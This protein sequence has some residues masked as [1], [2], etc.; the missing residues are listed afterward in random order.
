MLAAENAAAIMVACYPNPLSAKNLAAVPRP[1]Q[2]PGAQQYEN[3]APQTGC[4]NSTAA[5]L[6]SRCWGSLLRVFDMVTWGM[7]IDTSGRPLPN[8][9]FMSLVNVSGLCRHELTS[10]CMTQLGPIGCFLLNLKDPALRTPLFEPP[11]PPAPPGAQQPQNAGAGGGGGD[12]GDD[13]PNLVA[14]LVGTLGGAA[15][16]AALG[17][18][19]ALLWRRRQAQARAQAGGGKTAPDAHDDPSAAG[20]RRQSPPGDWEQASKAGAVA[21]DSGLAS[22]GMDSRDALTHSRYPAIAL[23]PSCAPYGGPSV[24]SLQTPFKPGLLTSITVSDPAEGAAAVEGRGGQAE[25]GPATEDGP[26]T[27]AVAEGPV[28]AVTAGSGACRGEAHDASAGAPDPG[29]PV[30]QLTSRVLGKGT[31]GRVLEGTL[32]GMPVA[33][34]QMGDLFEGVS[35]EKTYAFVQELEVLARCEHPNIVRLLAAC[36]KPP[37]PCIVMELMATSLDKVLYGR[38]RGSLLP[39][40]LVLHIGMEI[41]QGLDYLHPTVMH[42]DL[43]PANVLLNDPTSDRPVVKLS[44][45]GISRLRHSMLVTQNPEAGTPAYV[46]PECFDVDVWQF[47]HK[48]DIYAFGVLLWEMLA[49]VQP[50]SGLEPVNIAMHVTMLGKRLPM[51]PE[52]APGSSKERWPLKVKQLI[53]ECWD[54][55]PLRRPAAMEL[56]KRLA[57]VRNALEGGHQAKPAH[58]AAGRL[59]VSVAG[60]SA[61]AAGGGAP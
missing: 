27:T 23:G 55:D 61:A 43:K 45:F 31:F 6:M 14:I 46:A 41:A 16:L 7:D 26:T 36:V 5:P 33:V 1:P 2:Y 37:K 22:S 48:V 51:P 53:E 32:N 49:G 13:G 20:L 28:A 25:A 40:D 35:D 19:A 34:K 44:D 24:V 39:L 4:V 58:A 54:K 50:W 30:V 8:G 17:L 56:L 18:G 59:S 10:D 60:S 12:G 21:S 42:R 38:G 47:N 9:Y 52:E 57:L 29:V 3:K 15:L 11:Q